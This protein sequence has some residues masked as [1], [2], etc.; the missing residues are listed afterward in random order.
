MVTGHEIGHN[1]GCVHNQEIQPKAKL[2]SYFKGYEYGN[3][4]DDPKTGKPSG[5][6][7]IMG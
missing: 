7:T 6:A 5:Y 1:F 3:L 2:P 4:I